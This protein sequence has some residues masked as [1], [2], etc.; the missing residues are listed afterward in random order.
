M[1]CESYITHASLA[2]IKHAVHLEKFGVEMPSVVEEE[3]DEEDTPA[4]AAAAASSEE[5]AEHAD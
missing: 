2:R 3:D 5:T 4:S 1:E